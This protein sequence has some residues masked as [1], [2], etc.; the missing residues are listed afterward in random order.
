MFFIVVI[1]LSIVGSIGCVMFGFVYMKYVLNKSIRK[2]EIYVIYI[3][4]LEEEFLDRELLGFFVSIFFLLVFVIIVII[5]SIFGL[6]FMKKNVIYIVLIVVIFLFV[7]L[8]YKFL[9]FKI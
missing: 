1:I 9:L 5:G 2:G 6:E 8:F 4:E 3:L 7:F